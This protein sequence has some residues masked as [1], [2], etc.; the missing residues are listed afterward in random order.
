MSYSSW[1][2]NGLTNR[3]IMERLKDLS[4]DEVIEYF[5]FEISVEKRKFS[6]YLK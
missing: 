2:N 1:V 3:E 6:S 4:D 5:R